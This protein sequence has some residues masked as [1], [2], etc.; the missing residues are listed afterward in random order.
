[1]VSSTEKFINIHMLKLDEPGERG[2]FRAYDFGS[3]DGCIGAKMV[4]IKAWNNSGDAECVTES[5][6]YQALQ[7]HFISGVP[8]LLASSYDKECQ[9]YALVIEA[10][11]DS[12]EDLLYMT[13]GNRFTEEMVLA[14]AIQL[15]R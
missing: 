7:S 2:V 6:V 13:P 1:M 14:V 4:I 12:L 11:G 8:S 10:L 9:V 3:P 15:V 5:R